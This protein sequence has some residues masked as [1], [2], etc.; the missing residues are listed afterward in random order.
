MLRDGAGAERERSSGVKGI[1]GGASGVGVYASGP[2]AGGTGG[3]GLF[4]E[5]LGTG[6]LAGHFGTGNVQVDNQLIVNGAGG[7][8]IRTDSQSDFVRSGAL[9]ERA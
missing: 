5:G 4:A 2:G 3:I 8:G 7:Q 9:R 1:G 6:G